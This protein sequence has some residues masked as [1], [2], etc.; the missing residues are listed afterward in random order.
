[1]SKETSP[2]AG[3]PY[4]ASK[5]ARIL[6]ALSGDPDWYLEIGTP[7]YNVAD[8]AQ[9]LDMDASNL[10]R[11]LLQL[12]ADGLVVREWRKHQIWN[13]IAGDHVDRL[14]LS[15][16][17]V[18]TMNRDKLSAKHWK[19]GSAQRVAT[20]FDSMFAPVPRPALVVST[21][22]AKHHNSATELL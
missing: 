17:N 9:R 19:D 15:F 21:E 4:D 1:M 20:A 12:E 11:A 2:K 5:R 6:A 10:R 18:S 7:P 8:V 3:R 13:A 14:C 16:W 22:T